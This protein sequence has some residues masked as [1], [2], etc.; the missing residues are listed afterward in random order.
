[1]VRSGVNP[2]LLLGGEYGNSLHV[3]DLRKG[4]HQQKIPLGD[5]YQMTLG[6]ALPVTPRRRMGSSAW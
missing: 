2:E 6:C 1:M 4:N 3:W 5:E